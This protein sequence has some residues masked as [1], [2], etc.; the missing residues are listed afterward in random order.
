MNNFRLV[1]LFVLLTYASIRAAEGYCTETVSL[2]SRGDC[3][4]V[5]QRAVGTTADGIFGEKTRS[6]VIAFQHRT[7]LE[8]DGIVG[9][10]T[11]AA[12]YGRL[13]CLR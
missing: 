8:A 4:R 2:G 7:G 12:I 13:D 6:A 5:V 11:W 9:P 1:A 3:V 10:Y